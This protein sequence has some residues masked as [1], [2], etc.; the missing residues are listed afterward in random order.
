MQDA[1]FSE[2][3]GDQL[4]RLAAEGLTDK[5]IAAALGISPETVRTY[6][7]RLR[8]RSS[9][10]N[11][12]EVIA[13]WLRNDSLAALKDLANCRQILDNLK[14]FLWSA[15]PSGEILFCNA[16]FEQY[17][18]V[19]L[20][21]FLKDG[22]RPILHPSEREASSNR[23][24]NAQRRAERYGAVVHFKRTDGIYCAHQLVMSPVGESTNQSRPSGWIGMAEQL[25]NQDR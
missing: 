2:R 24:A 14:I 22:C 12:S 16:W 10:R 6:W 5:E 7:G 17:S 20:S 18:G 15:S 9:A 4:L 21:S 19:S 8:A 3:R 25:V 1:H 13:K 11:R 23:W